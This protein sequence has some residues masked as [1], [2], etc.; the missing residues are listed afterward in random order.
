MTAPPPAPAPAEKKE[1]SLKF[2]AWHKL[3]DASDCAATLMG[4]LQAPGHR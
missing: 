2:S 3:A 1:G 4:T